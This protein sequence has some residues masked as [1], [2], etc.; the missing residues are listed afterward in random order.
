M[1]R[2]KSYLKNLPQ[3]DS[4]SEIQTNSFKALTS[5]LPSDKFCLR[6][7][8]IEDYGVD[9]SLEIF[10][11]GKATNFRAQIQLKGTRSIEFNN[12][13]SFSL[14][15]DTSNLNYLLNNPISLYILYLESN[16]EFRLVWARNEFQRLAEENP[17]WIEQQTITIRF[18]EILDLGKL[19]E[20]R[21]QIINHSSLH[22]E[23][24]ETLV[25]AQSSNILLEINSETFEITDK[26]VLLDLIEV[27]G[28]NLVNE[29]FRREILDKINILDSEDKQKSSVVTVKAYA[30]YYSGRYHTAKET[31][32]LLKLSGKEIS[33]D[34][35]Q[36]LEWLE[37]ACDY[38]LGIINSEEHT[39]RL[40]EI[41]SNDEDE[42]FSSFR[43]DYIHRTLLSE[44][45]LEK[46]NELSKRLREEIDKLPADE[47]LNENIWQ[48][49]FYVLEAELGVIL[50]E[51]TTNLSNIS[52]K[53]ELGVY[54]NI[55]ELSEALANLI[56]SHREEVKAW[57][58]EF[59]E[60]F[61]STQ[62]MVLKADIL[63]EI[64]LLNISE[65]SVM[66]FHSLKNGVPFQEIEDNS[67][68]LCKQLIEDAI[69][70]YLNS[71]LY[72]RKL[73]AE[74]YLAE[75][76][77]LKGKDEEAEKLLL[78]IG[79]T[80]AKMS[81]AQVK[82]TSEKSLSKI[83][84]KVSELLEDNWIENSDEDLD[85]FTQ[86]LIENLELPQDRF[87]NV[88]SDVWAHREIEK[89][90]INWCQ[91]IELQQD[92]THEKKLVPDFITKSIYS[93]YCRKF[94][95]TSLFNNS[96]Y[97][98]VVSAFKVNYCEKCTFKK[99]KIVNVSDY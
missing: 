60:I 62:N 6:D 51:L 71:N 72:E 61:N 16:D 4:N 70:I 49:K 53:K 42:K 12:D 18:N 13:G 80:S 43:F 69:T 89:E 39:E 23:L 41:A 50:A 65:L 77:K 46:R 22:R 81:Y 35:L 3:V 55:F 14:Q 99:P 9:A 26:E 96:D 90:Q 27:L 15:V 2:K 92:L 20:I 91:Y 76:L 38:R 88:R 33:A 28:I 97:E 48:F 56:V 67:F 82:K 32:S 63:T 21:E 58:T 11:N 10:D 78:D 44:V 83:F 84:D 24:T 95:I 54:R 45:N 36:I 75:L 66:R 64:V 5:L 1:T 52:I 17:K 57:T 19:N 59:L 93:C 86:D 73:R 94:N 30:E 47:S 40:G 74:I 85:A 37:S 8:R 87:E 79:V 25:L 31:V 34:W 98:S 68:Y 29:G 7:E